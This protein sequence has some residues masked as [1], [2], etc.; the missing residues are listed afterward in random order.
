[1]QEKSSENRNYGD[2]K[3]WQELVL[4]GDLI[5]PHEA[6]ARFAAKFKPASAMDFGCGT[7]RHLA[8]LAK[9][10]AKKLI[11][12]DIN[13]LPLAAVALKF[14]AIK[15]AK[16]W[17]NGKKLNLENG[18]TLELFCNDDKNLSEILSDRK[19]DAVISWGV[20]HLYE[21]SAAA[22]ILK[23]FANSLNENGRVFINLRTNADG[24]KIGAK[25]INQNIYETTRKG[26]EGLVYSFYSKADVNDIFKL[27]GLKIIA[28]DKE[29]F[30]QNNGEI[31]N[32][33]YIVEALKEAK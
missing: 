25:Q 5:Y 31:F 32:S 12:V 28:L 9:A 18:T 27:A 21:P 11:G 17:E 15:E 19:V 1:M 30:T 6:V 16:E 10:G 23:E 24:L 33:F 29:E 3:K 20:L 4:K 2:L 22:E 8:C 13:A 7:G 14:G 26:Y